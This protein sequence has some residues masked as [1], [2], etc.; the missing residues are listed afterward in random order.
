MALV[1]NE[2][3]W[4]SSTVYPVSFLDSNG[5]GFGYPNNSKL[6]YL[7]D[8]GVD[9]VWPRRLT[10]S[11]AD[12]R[13]IDPRYGTLEY[14]DNLLKRLHRR[15]M[16]LMVD[17]VVNTSY[18]HPSLL[19]VSTN[20]SSNPAEVKTTRNAIGTLGD[21]QSTTLTDPTD[22]PMIGHRYLDIARIQS[23]LPF[24]WT[25]DEGTDEYL[26]SSLISTGRILPCA[27]LC[28][29][30][31]DSGWTKAAID[32]EWTSSTSSQKQMDFLTRREFQP[33]GIHYVNGPRVHHY[34]K[35]MREKVLSHYDLITVGETPFTELMEIALDTVTPVLFNTA[36]QV[37]YHQQVA[38]LRAGRRFL[39]H[40]V[41]RESRSASLRLRFGNDSTDALRSLS[42]K[43]LA[44][45]EV[46][47]NGT[48]YVYQGQELSMKNFPRS[49]GGSDPELLE[50]EQNKKAEEVNMQ[51]ISRQ[52]P[53][54]GEGPCDDAHADASSH[55]DY[56]SW[57]AETQLKDEDSVH[58]SRE[59]AVPITHLRRI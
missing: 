21:R 30:L 11:S 32:S 3:W 18:E 20:G 29:T 14:W 6:D 59:E 31:C 48:L 43:L 27:T 17:L 56:K 33:A 8:L 49:W 16:K 9:V 15:Q 4:K 26:T 35:E 44:M 39:E 46:T 19:C 28:G 37:L 1:A 55:G 36:S 41:H 7:K 10:R 13:A 58:V 22:P 38:G 52:F 12:Y 23:H 53:E 42:A 57:N 24:A 54:E 25:Y 51:D 45:L 50:S 34:I 2:S 47:Q 5:D 40:S